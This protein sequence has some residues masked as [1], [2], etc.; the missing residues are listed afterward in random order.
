MEKVEILM[1]TYNGEKY[2]EKQ[3]KSIL[4]QTYKN[5]TLLIRDDGSTDKTLEIIKKFTMEDYRIKLI[6]DNK[7]NL[8]YKKNFEELM[9]K[10]REKFIFLCDQ[11]DIWLENKIEKCMKYLSKYRLIHHNAEVFFELSG[12]KRKLLNLKKKRKILAKFIFPNFVGCCMAFRRE[13]LDVVL[14]VPKKYPGHDTWIGI[15]EE[16][17]GEVKYIDD[18]LIIYRRHGNNTSALAEKSKNSLLKKIKF[19][20]YYLF[21]PLWRILKWKIKKY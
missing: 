6:I 11:D 10:S 3:I 2:L 15:L 20:Y 9:T 4:S 7:G 18:K 8:G 13:I 16:W 12:E 19:R 5:W 21:Y 14:P 17:L 1:A